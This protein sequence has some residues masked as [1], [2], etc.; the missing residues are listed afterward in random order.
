MHDLPAGHQGQHLDHPPLAMPADRAGIQHLERLRRN[1]VRRVDH[2][3]RLEIRGGGMATLGQRV[4]GA[5]RDR[6]VVTHHDRPHRQIWLPNRQPVRHQVQFAAPE[7]VER[8][9]RKRLV[10]NDLTP[11]MRCREHPHDLS[12]HRPT[13]RE[14]QQADPQLP[15]DPRRHLA[16]LTE[17][18]VDLLVGRTQPI[19]QLL[20]QRRQPHPPRRPLEQHAADPRLQHTHCLTDPRRRQVQPLRR[21]AEMQLLGQNQKDLD[22]AEFHHTTPPAPTTCYAGQSVH[23]G[24]V[25]EVSRCAADDQTTP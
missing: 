14:V 2:R 15:G 16:D 19:P 4:P 17:R 9:T 1:H 24:Q 23:P 18:L 8:L 3:K 7:P 5:D 20:A 22:L 25:L 21:P 10:D 6:A 12:E 11:G 13:G